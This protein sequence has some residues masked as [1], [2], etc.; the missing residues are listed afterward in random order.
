M[1]TRGGVVPRTRHEVRPPERLARLQVGCAQLRPSRDGRSPHRA[2]RCDR[3]RLPARPRL[4]HRVR[5]A[6]RRPEHRFHP[7]AAGLP[8]L[9][10]GALLPTPLLL[11]QVLL[12]GLPALP[13]RAR[14]GDLRRH[15]GPDP[16]AGARAGRRLGRVVHHRGRRAVPAAAPRRLVGSPRRPLVRHGRDAADLRGAQGPEVPLVLRRHPDPAPTLAPHAPGPRRRR[17]PH[18][19]GP[20]LGLPVRRRAVVR[21]PAGR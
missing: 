15:H 16:T 8:R 6:V 10:A 14:R 3:R 7:G 19:P 4:P 13:Q 2:D 21:R 12:R 17:E 9:A 18:G 5:P 11:L 1:A 20:A